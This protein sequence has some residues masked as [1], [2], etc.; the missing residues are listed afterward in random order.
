[1][2]IGK[3]IKQYVVFVHYKNERGH[4]T[5]HILILMQ[6]SVLITVILPIDHLHV[7]IWLAKFTSILENY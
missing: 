6:F 3:Y 2:Y 5:Y 1:M 4:G 7:N